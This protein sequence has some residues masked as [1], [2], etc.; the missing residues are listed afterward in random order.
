MG[1]RSTQASAL[2]KWPWTDPSMDGDE[3]QRPPR[4]LLTKYSR[5][6]ASCQYA[7]SLACLEWPPK[8]PW[9]LEEPQ[10]HL[11]VGAHAAKVCV[12]HHNMLHASTQQY[13]KA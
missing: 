2:S 8:N 4:V 11:Q 12:P 5:P 6:S 9:H 3:R 7:A 13:F 10:R 1:I